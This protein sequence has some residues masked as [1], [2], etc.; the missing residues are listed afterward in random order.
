MVCFLTPKKQK[1]VMLITIRQKRIRLHEHLF[2][3]T[4][5]DINLQLTTWDKI[6]SVTVDQNLQWTNHIQIVCK[7]IS[8]YIWLLS[9]IKSYLSMER[10]SLFYKA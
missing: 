7:K 5:N 8:L 2:N 1:K 3:L 9:K 6:L 4:Y 10:R